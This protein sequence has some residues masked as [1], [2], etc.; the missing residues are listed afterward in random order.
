MQSDPIFSGG[1]E[2]K[3]LALCF[4]L[5]LGVSLSTNVAA[6][7]FYSQS[8]CHSGIQVFV[9]DVRWHGNIPRPWVGVA[10]RR[11]HE[12]AGSAAVCRPHQC[13]WPHLSWLWSAAQQRDPYALQC[14]ADHG[15][16]LGPVRWLFRQLL[17]PRLRQYR[18]GKSAIHSRCCRRLLS[19]NWH[20]EQ[21]GYGVRFRHRR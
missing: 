4:C 10:D 21:Q 16:N 13:R 17:L 15:D 12:S 20:I 8:G 19:G 6:L 9:P 14:L 5:G 11:Q 1:S 2:I 7:C 3:K 18:M